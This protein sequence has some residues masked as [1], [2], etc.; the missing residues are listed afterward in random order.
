ML[1]FLCIW[2][3]LLHLL[4]YLYVC[5]LF[6]AIVS[7]HCLFIIFSFFGAVRGQ[8]FVI[9]ASAWYLHIYLFSWDCCS[10]FIRLLF[11]DVVTCPY[12]LIRYICRTLFFYRGLHWDPHIG[13]NSD[14]N[15]SFVS[16]THINE[17]ANSKLG[18][19]CCS[20]FFL[21]V[22]L[23]FH[24]WCLCCP[25]YFFISYSLSASEELCFVILAFS[26]YFHLFY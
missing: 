17:S 6:C 22:C 25:Y 11:F 13:T 8:Y 9:V 20:S 15:V 7:C 10:V 26:V 18:L 1:R 19:L 12:N 3:V 23:C 4:F 21:C 2:S 16:K 14:K 24:M 5:Y